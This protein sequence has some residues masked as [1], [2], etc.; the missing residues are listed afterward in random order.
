MQALQNIRGRGILQEYTQEMREE[1]AAMKIIKAVNPKHMF[2]KNHVEYQMMVL[3][4]DAKPKRK[5]DGT[6]ELPAAKPITGSQI[7]G[8]FSTFLDKTGHSISEA[9]LTGY[10]T[11]L[12]AAFVQWLLTS[13]TARYRLLKSDE[14]Q[15][16]LADVCRIVVIDWI[17]IEK[18]NR[19]V[20]GEET[21]ADDSIRAEMETLMCIREAEK[22]EIKG[23]MHSFKHNETAEERD[24]AIDH[25]H[26][27]LME[28][29]EGINRP[30]REV[31]PEEGESHE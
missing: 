29:L 7:H 16:W 12:T 31:L 10:I 28:R 17:M 26:N 30:K 4:P 15:K 19:Y 27:S 1:R 20:D 6:I 24:A 18:Y 3:D 14:G 13:Y 25:R 8:V 23:D 9:W 2:R 11:P 5:K 22:E 21:F